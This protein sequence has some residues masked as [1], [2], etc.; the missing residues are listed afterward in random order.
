MT[1]AQRVPRGIFQ[2]PH[3]HARG[4]T[5]EKLFRPLEAKTVFSSYLPKHCNWLT[6]KCHMSVPSHALPVF[7]VRLNSVSN[8]GQFTLEAGTFFDRIG[9]RIAVG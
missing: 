4:D 7:Q 9:L 6:E 8:E 3:I 2:S 1:Q 5:D